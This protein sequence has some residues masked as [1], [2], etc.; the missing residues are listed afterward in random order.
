MYIHEIKCHL[1]FFVY[2]DFRDTCGSGMLCDIT[3][4]NDGIKDGIFEQ[5]FKYFSELRRLRE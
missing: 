4:C 1:L 3:H 5:K 2:F